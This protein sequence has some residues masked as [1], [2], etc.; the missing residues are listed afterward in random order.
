MWGNSAIRKLNNALRLLHFCEESVTISLSSAFL[1]TFL[2]MNNLQHAFQL[3]DDYNKQD[4]NKLTYEGV[5]YPEE[6]FYAQHVY[7]WVKKLDQN[8]SEAL[9]LASRCQHIGRWELPRSQ[10][11]EG[12]VGYLKWRSDLAKEHAEKAAEL[13]IKAGY[14][15]SDLI[16]RVQ[17]IILKKQI[18]TD[19][20]VQVMEDA[21]CLVFLQF[22][23]EDFLKKHDDV[24]LIRILQKTWNKM[25]PQGREAALS[26]SY[27]VKGSELLQRALGEGIIS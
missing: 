9:L 23:F 15:D 10:Y 27:S 12:R 1:T 16:A 19:H 26:L 3:F 20:D 18:K 17:Q 13:L 2:D 5:E 7:N 8:A 11:P 6:F 14:D 22:E 24:K 4:P 21:L 25:S